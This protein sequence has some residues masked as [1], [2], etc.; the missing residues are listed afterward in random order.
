LIDYAA[1]LKPSNGY[2]Q[3]MAIDKWC[4]RCNQRSAF[5]VWSSEFW[6]L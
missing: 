6:V 4:T 2:L 1:K 3:K 5:S